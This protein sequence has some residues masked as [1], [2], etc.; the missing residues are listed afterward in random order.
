[1]GIVDQTVAYVS[2]NVSAKGAAVFVTASAT[3]YLILVRLERRRRRRRLGAKAP[4]A[5]YKIPWGESLRCLSH[6]RHPP[7][8]PAYKDEGS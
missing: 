1:M 4:C 7:L 6:S 3:L 8:A 5:P 2:D